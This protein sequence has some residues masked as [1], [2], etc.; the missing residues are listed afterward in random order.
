MQLYEGE[1]LTLWTPQ[2]DQVWQIQ[3]QQP[4]Q[5]SSLVVGVAPDGAVALGEPN[6]A[7][8]IAAGGIRANVRPGPRISGAGSV[9]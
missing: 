6:V 4:I 8:A 3:A 2:G 5:I 7:G 9:R 1:R